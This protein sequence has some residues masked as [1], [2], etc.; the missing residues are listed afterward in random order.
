MGLF[1]IVYLPLLPIIDQINLRMDLKKALLRDHSRAQAAKIADYVANKE[2]LFK[3]LVEVYLA[4]PY[5]ITQRAA[6]PLSI[7]VE[8]HP[9]LIKPHL[10]RILGY[11]DTPGIPDAVKRNTIRLLQFVD[12][13][14]SYYGRV[15]KI[16]F[17]YL[18]N[19]KEPV[20]VR[21]FS[22]TVLSHITR[23]EPELKREL[24]IIIEDHLPYAT[25]GFVSRARKVLKEIK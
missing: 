23:N 14:G 10:S 22:M 21:V 25:P 1:T 16:C 9:R 15:A 18:G 5:R 3:E 8:R 11:L 24:G 6:W 12:I 2:A 17:N 7:C 13:P 19:R 4:G 20:A